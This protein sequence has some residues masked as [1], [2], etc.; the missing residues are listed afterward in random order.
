M[1]TGSIPSATLAVLQLLGQGR[2]KTRVQ[3]EPTVTFG[4]VDDGDSSDSMLK[5]VRI[6]DTVKAG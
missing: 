3:G 1:G 4:G 2:D 6:R 5:G